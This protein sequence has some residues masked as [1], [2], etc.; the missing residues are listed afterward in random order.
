[1]RTTLT[2]RT[3]AIL[4]SLGTGSAYADNA[5]V[6]FLPPP[7][8]SIQTGPPSVSIGPPEAYP[9]FTIGGVE[10]RVWA[11]GELPYNSKINE[12]L[13]SIDIWGAG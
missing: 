4:V 12:D 1:M 10:V 5:D 6:Q 3:A 7:F 13:T 2:L 11:P 9:L 8:T